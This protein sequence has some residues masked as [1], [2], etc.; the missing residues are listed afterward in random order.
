MDCEREPCLTEGSL[1]IVAGI[2]RS[3]SEKFRQPRWFEKPH[4]RFFASF[5]SMEKEEKKDQAKVEKISSTQW[6]TLSYGEEPSFG[7]GE[8]RI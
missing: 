5:S 7:L 4:H 1:A 3:L 6:K 2:S 8:L